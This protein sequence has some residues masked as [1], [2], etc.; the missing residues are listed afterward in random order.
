MT[1]R[2]T[3][4]TAFEKPRGINPPVSQ[5]GY[6]Q[7]LIEGIPAPIERGRLD[8]LQAIAKAGINVDFLKLTQSGISCVVS[9]KDVEKAKGAV[10]DLPGDVQVLGGRAIVLAHAVNMR[11]E[12][13][14]MARVI[15]DVIAS[16]APIDHLG[17]MHDRVLIVTS[18]EGAE[19]IKAAISTHAGGQPE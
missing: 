5:S 4:G 3:A 14:L 6:A 9:E 19:R 17:D 1:E 7:I 8:V 18:T 11:D 13:G 10:A 2:Q 16:E 15:R 12:E